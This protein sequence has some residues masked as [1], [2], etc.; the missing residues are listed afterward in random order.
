MYMFDNPIHFK[1]LTN[2]NIS[3][4]LS[5][6]K[7]LS[8]TIEIN[9]DSINIKKFKELVEL[10]PFIQIWLIQDYTNKNIIGC[11]T[12]II[13]PKFIH[14][15]GYVGHIEDV[16]ISPEYQGKGYGKQI[17]NQLIDISKINNCYKIILNCKRENIPFYEKCG[18]VESQT[19]MSIYFS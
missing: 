17:I 12:I 10:Y 15:C 19:Q 14:K 13:E 1:L 3:E 4:Y 9:D 11:G 2:D 6:L 8:D 5:I 16:C 18:F 7:N